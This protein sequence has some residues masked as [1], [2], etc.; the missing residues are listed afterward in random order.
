MLVYDRPNKNL[1]LLFRMEGLVGDVDGN[2]N[3]DDA[4]CAAD[5]PRSATSRASA[6]QENYQV[7]IDTNCD[8]LPEVEIR[9][10]GTG[11]TRSA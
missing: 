6:R 9:V 11:R 8:G 3:P 1:Y 5:A 4:L 7:R 10:G 2:G